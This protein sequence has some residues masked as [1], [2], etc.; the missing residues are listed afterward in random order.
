MSDNFDINNEEY[1]SKQVDFLNSTLDRTTYSIIS[2]LNVN[3]SNE[4][5]RRISRDTIRRAL[6]SPYDSVNTLQQAS[7]MLKATNG[8]YAEILDMQS[9]MLTDDHMLIPINTLNIKNP[10]KLRKS[11]NETS[12]FLSL[13]NV[14]S[15]SPWIR[16]RVL[17]QGELYTY[18]LS[19]KDGV[20][21]QEIP[22]SF[23]KVTKKENNVYRYAVNLN[24][25]TTETI[26]YMPKE[27]SLAYKKLKE[28]KLDKKKLIDS[29]YFEV[30]DNG[31]AFILQEN[32][33]KNIP[34]YSSVFDDFIELEDKKDLKSANDILSAIRLIHQ[35]LPYDKDSG[36][37]LINTEQAKVIHNST[38]ANLPKDTKIVTHHLD[39]EVL[40]LSDSN[41]RL[42]EGIIQ[43]TDSVYQSAGIDSDLFNGKKNNTESIIAGLI[44]NSLVPFKIQRMICDWLNYKL[45]K[46]K[47]Q[48]IQFKLKF[49]ESTYFNKDEKLKSSRE[50]MAYGGSRLEFIATS[51]YT[52]DEGVNLLT[53]ESMLG[54]DELL[55]PQKSSHTL[56]KSDISSQTNNKKN[57]SDTVTDPN[58]ESGGTE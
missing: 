49:I 40:N 18:E 45:S 15:I 43:A 30:G 35:K 1:V 3:I 10:E 41:S 11:F 53:A 19:S 17:E 4:R 16:S 8:I 21:L 32:K 14:K 28:N 9:N 25:F 13:Y 48:S 42:S 56:S 2:G 29:T 23:C 24:A 50:N 34:Y 57:N 27:I 58:D 22:A 54:V 47:K 5:Y 38:K 12:N 52:P 55:V 44:V 26:K 37:L 31:V 36:K 20:I 33:T 39:M 51:G 7:V 6:D 46:N